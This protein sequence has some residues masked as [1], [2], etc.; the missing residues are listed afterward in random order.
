MK[1]K[2]QALVAGA[3]TAAIVTGAF[4]LGLKDTKK[5]ID[6]EVNN[7]TQ[8]IRVSDPPT[9]V[10]EINLNK[11]GLTLCEHPKDSRKWIAVRPGECK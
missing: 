5:T 6:I 4:Y 8:L 3:A 1:K 10:D 11:I 7:G 2:S 9:P